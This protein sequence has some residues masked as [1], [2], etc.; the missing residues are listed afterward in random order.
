MKTKTMILGML[1]LGCSLA[2]GKSELN[3]PEDASP[4][5]SKASMAQN[6]SMIIHEIVHEIVHEIIEPV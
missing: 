2:L 3:K 6:E 5:F 1:I 4:I